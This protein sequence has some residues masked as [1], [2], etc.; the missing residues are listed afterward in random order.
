MK[1]ILLIT[2]LSIN[3][4]GLSNMMVLANDVVK[5]ESSE[6]TELD[7]H[8]TQE[9]V[10][11]GGEEHAGGHDSHGL[12]A[13]FFIIIA[14]LVGAAT[15]HFLKKS[16]IP[17]TVM[18]LLFGLGLGLL[19]RQGFFDVWEFG[20]MEMDV[21]IIHQSMDWA[22]N[23]NPHLLLFVFLPILI[24][25]AAFAMDV[26]VFKKSVTNATILAVPGI[27]IALGLTAAM[28]I[29]CQMLGIGFEGWGWPMALM[30]GSVISATD[31]VAVVA[32]LKELGASKKLGTLI[33]GESL[34]NDGTAIVIFM[35]FFLGI[36]GSASETNGFV[37]FLYVAVG[38][39][40][41]GLIIGGVVLAW[42]KKVF[43]DALVEISVIVAAAYLAFFAAEHFL[44]VSGVLAL[45]A[46]GLVMAGVGRTRI[47]PEVEHFMH[48]FWELAGFIA[49]CL[50]FLIVGVV[51]AI[52][53]EFSMANFIMLGIIYVG[54]H[55][56]RAIVIAACYPFMKNTG[57]GLPVKDAIVVWYGALRGAIGL[58][59]AL[60]VANAEV[61]PVEIRDQFLFLIAGT[62]TLTL[63]VNATTIR[64]L[65]NKL[66]LTDIPPVKAI[67][68]SNAYH[69]ISVNSENSVDL[70][71]SD[72]FM[73]GANWNA[74][75]EFIPAPI[76]F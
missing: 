64:F 30:F 53:V 50:L 16:P 45:V 55:V 56:V 33:E 15:R 59:L 37:E 39:T 49:N 36:T 47:S 76:K 1:R 22:A 32:L 35:V 61:I 27:C 42:V 73:S 48:E 8:A 18:L 70:L 14:L 23:I 21:H 25:E 28:V 13:L 54:I 6:H 3:I 40:V 51:I 75:R 7:H 46:L 44:H 4:A 67:M 19:A 10:G 24:F 68:M 38:G 11:H 62:V 29:G 58:A 9:A 52:R 17:F 43:N 72:R 2:F 66:G 65:V 74:V 60:I 26:H 20:F 34:L 31:P 69:N 12:D 63:L 57:Y 41:V 71:K 5:I